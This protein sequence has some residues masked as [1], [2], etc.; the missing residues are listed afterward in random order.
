M[1]KVIIIVI[2]MLSGCVD[3][4]RVGLHPEGKSEYFVGE[5]SEVENCIESSATRLNLSIMLDDTLPGGTKRYNLRDTNDELIA[6][7]EISDFNSG[8]TDVDFFY[9]PHAP[10]V[11]NAIS[12]MIQQCKHSLY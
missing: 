6:W 9:A 8:Q 11:K 2:C 4:G 5:R 10:D 1:N 12:R 7:I 3:L